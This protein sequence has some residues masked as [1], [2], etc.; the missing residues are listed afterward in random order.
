MT[1]S[2]GST[3]PVRETVLARAVR[4]AGTVPQAAVE[5]RRV[6][7]G[8]GVCLECERDDGV[9]GCLVRDEP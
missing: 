1:S 4:S 3:P 2:N 9:R 8:M 6:F 7:C 5:G